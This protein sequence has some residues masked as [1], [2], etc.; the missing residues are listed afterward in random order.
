MFRSFSGVH[1]RKF[2]YKNRITIPEHLSQ[3][4]PVSFQRVMAMKGA[5]DIPPE[6]G[7]AFKFLY[8]WDM[9]TW[10]SLLEE[11]YR[12]M[13]EDAARKFMHSVVADSAAADVDVSSRVTVP[14]RLLQYAGIEKQ[15]KAIVAGI[16]DHLEIWSFDSWMAYQSSPIVQEDVKIPLIPDLARSRIREVS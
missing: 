9:E 2:D 11:A 16:F 14:E 6:D 1:E 4:G 10:D 15:A 12:R 8:F 13:D 3:S 5:S 7:N